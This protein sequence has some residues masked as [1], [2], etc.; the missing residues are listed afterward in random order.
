MALV[1][2]S[3]ISNRTSLSHG[4]SLHDSNANTIGTNT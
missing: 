2:D 3:S 1:P 4:W